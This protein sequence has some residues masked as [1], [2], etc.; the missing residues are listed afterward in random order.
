M[1]YG[2]ADKFNLSYHFTS[3]RRYLQIGCFALS[4]VNYAN[5]STC[6]DLFT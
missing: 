6:S 5:I 2:L 4:L 3:P 1:N